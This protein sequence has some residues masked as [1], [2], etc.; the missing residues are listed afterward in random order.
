MK[1]LHFHGP[2][3]LDYRKY[4][5][6]GSTSN[7]FFDKFLLNKVYLFYYKFNS[8]LI[9]LLKSHNNNEYGCENKFGSLIDSDPC[10]FYLF[11]I[12]FIF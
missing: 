9:S 2:K 7:D 11:R 4:I 12:L 10:R 1:I 8:F 6:S 5:Y 3:V